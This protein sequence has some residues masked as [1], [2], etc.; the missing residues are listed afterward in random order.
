MSTDQAGAGPLVIDSKAATV[1]VTPASPRWSI[2]AVSKL[3]TVDGE[4]ATFAAE[5]L[6]CQCEEPKC[7]S[8][9]PERVYKL[10]RK[11]S[12]TYL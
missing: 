6:V 7:R 10:A 1:T 5:I 9:H 3:R 8:W 4:P 2:T 12:A 11:V